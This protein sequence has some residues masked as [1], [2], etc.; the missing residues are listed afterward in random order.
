MTEHEGEI[1][2]T[3][4]AVP[5]WR[6]VADLKWVQPRRFVRHWELRDGE[7]KLAFVW[8][9]G[10]FHRGFSA[11]ARD[12]EWRLEHPF[13]W[14]SMSIRREGED[15]PEIQ[16]RSRFLGRARIER[17]AGEELD[18]R[19]EGWLTYRFLLQTVEG[20]PLIRFDSKRG[21][22]RREA[23][24]TLEDAARE[25]P[26][27]EQLILLGWSLVLATQRPHAR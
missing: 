27:L 8:W 9:R 1:S 7:E 17:R 16:A 18:W 23:G 26:D 13:F 12:G 24:V 21:F 22:F 3:L 25:L 19:R 6:R 5:D 2:P 14:N 20:L 15:D 11:L 4:L 10:A